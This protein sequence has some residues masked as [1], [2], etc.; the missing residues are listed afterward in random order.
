MGR[1]SGLLLLAVILM[2]FQLYHLDPVK[3][4]NVKGGWHF[5]MFSTCQN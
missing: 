4:A 5:Q 2:F 1:R 3:K